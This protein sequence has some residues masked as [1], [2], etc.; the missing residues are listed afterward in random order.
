MTAAGTLLCPSPVVQE[1][2]IDV[3]A[4]LAAFGQG[5]VEEIQPPIF[6]Q[7]PVGIREIADTEMDTDDVAA[8]QL[9]EIGRAHV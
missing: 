1:G 9:D 3:D 8:H 4:P 7:I 6:D 5:V 2:Q